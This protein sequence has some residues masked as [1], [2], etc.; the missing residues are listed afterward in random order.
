[1]REGKKPLKFRNV[2]LLAEAGD[3]SHH[4]FWGWT[5][6]MTR[7]LGTRRGQGWG[8]VIQAHCQTRDCAETEA[9]HFCGLISC[10]NFF[11]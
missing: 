2:C 10:G 1:M 11:F 4:L 5:P 3:E 8:Q 7:R 9:R 6:G